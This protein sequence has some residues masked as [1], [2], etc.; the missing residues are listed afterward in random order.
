MAMEEV[1]AFRVMRMIESVTLYCIKVNG[2]SC[3]ILKVFL[4]LC[5]LLGGSWWYLSGVD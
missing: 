1:A 3:G 4:R 5:I 2:I